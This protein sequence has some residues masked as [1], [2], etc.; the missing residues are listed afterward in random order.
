M[1]GSKDHTGCAQFKHEIVQSFGD[2]THFHIHVQAN[3]KPWN[4]HPKLLVA[5]LLVGAKNNR[6]DN[7]EE[8]E[9]DDSVADDM[10]KDV[11]SGIFAHLA[12]A[13]F[14]GNEQIH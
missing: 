2:T 9:D 1:H 3:S 5:R 7:G 6:H 8:E 13:P 11:A 12:I 14:V 10:M 4:K